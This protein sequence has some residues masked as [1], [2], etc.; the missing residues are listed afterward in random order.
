M[1]AHFVGKL[2]GL[3]PTWPDDM[4]DAEGEVMAEHFAYL[5]SKVATGEV[6]MAGPC[7]EDPP[8]GL[9]VLACADQAAAE[10][11]LAADPSVTG[12]LH[13]AEVVPFRLSLYAGEKASPN[14]S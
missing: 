1:A 12:G 11:L 5:K 7:F 2:I 9:V 10:A 6:L 3:R 13:R 14:A 8:V 4:T